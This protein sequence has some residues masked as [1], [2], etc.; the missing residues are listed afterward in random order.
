[1]AEEEFSSVPSGMRKRAP[2]GKIEEEQEGEVNIAAPAPSKQPMQMPKIPEMP[3][4]GMEM[5]KISL[6]A[7]GG[8]G[9]PLITVAL[10]ALLSLYMA[11]SAG[12]EVGRIKSEASLLAQDL[13]AF[14]NRDASIRAPVDG[15]VTVKKDVPLAGVFPPG[16]KVSGT[17]TIPLKT[18]LIGRST[19]GGVFEIPIDQNVTADF[20]APLD[21]SNAAQG[22]SIVLNEEIPLGNE[23]IIR[24]NAGEVWGPDLDA[25]IGRLEAI[26]K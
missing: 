26:A 20:E 24:V 7:G 1:M 19:T 8:I 25:A 13:Q 21:F 15:F 3:K 23:A 18:T 9:L 12:N 17:I 2:A 22:E 16:L 5:P 11:W 14:K 6:G 4:L 10:V